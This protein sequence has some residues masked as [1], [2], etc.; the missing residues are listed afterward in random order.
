MRLRSS[1]AVARN[2]LRVLAHDMLP[3]V[4]L[5]AMPLL[6]ILFVKPAFRLISTAEGLSG[7]TGAEQAIP[8]MQVIFGFFIAGQVCLGFYSEH[9][10]GTW[11]RVRASAT[12][13]T[14]LLLGKL[15]VPLLLAAVQFIVLFGLGGILLDLRVRGSWLALAAVGASF[16]VCLV[17]LGVA[18]TG[19]CRSILQVNAIT[20]I[21]A[22]LLSGLGGALVPISLLPEWAKV[23]ARATPSYWAM[24]GYEDVIRRGGNGWLV[25][26][27][28]L[29]A[30]AIAFTAIASWKLRF[31]D[32]KTGFA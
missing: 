11:N 28:A 13:S 15:A 7:A 3:L 16:G 30:F 4:L 18:L 12:S 1:I 8:G 10:W 27:A 32:A 22:L 5:F 29:L 26:V 17:T 23:L 31:E 14:D 9:A 20:S 19:L 2:D 6:T 25:A 21:C 24:R